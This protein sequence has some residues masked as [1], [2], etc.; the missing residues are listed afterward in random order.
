MQSCNL[1]QKQFNFGITYMNSFL[2][3]D[4]NNS[5]LKLVQARYNLTKNYQVNGL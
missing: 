2:S 1:T 4:V 3:F 5:L